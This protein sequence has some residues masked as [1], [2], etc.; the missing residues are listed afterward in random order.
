[1][2]FGGRPRVIDEVEAGCAAILQAWYPG[3]EGGKCCC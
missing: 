2:M 3:E 1:M